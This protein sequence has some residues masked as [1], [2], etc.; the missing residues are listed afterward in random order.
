M[1]ESPVQISILGLEDKIFAFNTP[2]DVSPQALGPLDLKLNLRVSFDADEEVVALFVDLRTSHLR[3]TEAQPDRLVRL[4]HYAGDMHFRVRGGREAFVDPDTTGQFRLPRDLVV[5]LLATTFST[6]R[7]I[8]YARLG[9]SELRHLIL[10][11]LDPEHALP[12]TGTYVIP[13]TA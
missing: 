11:L 4:I 12:D 9:T 5:S 1:A 2:E 3:P 7:G 13:V 6:F 10:P 8:V